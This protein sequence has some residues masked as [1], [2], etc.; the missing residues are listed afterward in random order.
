M[1]TKARA[2]Q[3]G[4]ATLKF[5]IVAALIAAAGYVG[6]QLIPLAYQSY[7]TKD[8]MQGLVDNAAL[9]AKSPDWV[10]EQL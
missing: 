4:G 2:S 1:N 3:Q 9:M 5:L 6:Y 8:L 7:Q 10:K